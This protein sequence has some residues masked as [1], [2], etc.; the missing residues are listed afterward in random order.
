MEGRLIRE[1]DLNMGKYGSPEATHLDYFLLSEKNRSIN[2]LDIKFTQKRITLR[3][4]G[5]K[6]Y[7][8]LDYSSDPLNHVYCSTFNLKIS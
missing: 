4:W 8:T 1:I 3:L 6:S 5:K 2:Y 7:K